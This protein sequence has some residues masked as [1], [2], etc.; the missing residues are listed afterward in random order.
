MYKDKR[1]EKKKT[2]TMKRN[3]NPIFNES[4]AF[5]IPTEKLRETTIIITV[6]DKDKL[7]RNDVI[8][9][10]GGKAGG[11]PHAWPAPRRSVLASSSRVVGEHRAGQREGEGQPLPRSGPASH[12]KTRGLDGILR[13]CQAVGRP[14]ADRPLEGQ[15]K[16][17]VGRR[18]APGP[19][20]RVFWTRPSGGNVAQAP[21]CGGRAMWGSAESCSRPPQT[22]LHSSP[23]LLLD[24]CVTLGESLASLSFGVLICKIELLILTL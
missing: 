7:S 17:D 10:V 9:K 21:T 5:D 6:M 16:K 12:L 8:G 19:T 4:F 15:G 1:V 2:V 13:K 11:V 3:L 20:K 24:S 18:G 23:H 22:Q 14:A